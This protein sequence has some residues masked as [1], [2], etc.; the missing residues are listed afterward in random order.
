MDHFELS[1]FEYKNKI[2]FQKIVCLEKF[3]MHR[4]R[5]YSFLRAQTYADT[6]RTPLF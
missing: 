4:I 5:K 2:I 6:Q 3:E 1:I